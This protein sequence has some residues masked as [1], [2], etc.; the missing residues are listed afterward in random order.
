MDLVSLNAT[1]GGCRRERRGVFRH[2]QTD[3]GHVQTEVGQE[4]LGSDAS[5]CQDPLETGG[6]E[7][8]FLRASRGP[9]AWVA[10][11]CQTSSL[12]NREIIN[13]LF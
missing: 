6:E 4:G 7:G 8:F 12:Q 5:H 3:R 13:G 9:L 10:P 11:R 2:R 1:T